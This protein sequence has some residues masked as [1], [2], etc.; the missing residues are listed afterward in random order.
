[1]NDSEFFGAVRDLLKSQSTLA[2]A[3][4]AEDGTPL[5]APLFYIVEDDLRMYW[6]SSASSEHSKNVERTGS[7]A[8]TVYRPTE[9]WNEIC[10][11]QM[12][13]KVSVVEDRELRRAVERE[14]T[15]RFQLG[16]LFE[17]MISRTK[18]YEFRPGWVRYLDNS[19]HVGYK[20][21]KRLE[22]PE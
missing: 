21:E 19:K 3:T 11:V 22:R 4:S 2:L 13:G 10:G 17:A 20:V 14:Y 9:R 5:V 16:V 15:E 6:F 18:L 1:M 7:G 12:T 8:V